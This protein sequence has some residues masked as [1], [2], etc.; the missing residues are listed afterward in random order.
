MLRLAGHRQFEALTLY[1][2]SWIHA[3]TQNRALALEAGLNSLNLLRSIND[4]FNTVYALRHLGDYY[5]ELGDFEQ[6]RS[7][8][9]E[10]YNIAVVQSHPLTHYLHARISA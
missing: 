6:A 5:Q 8:W 7:Y 3:K 10:A 2:L 1:E 9:Q 4:N